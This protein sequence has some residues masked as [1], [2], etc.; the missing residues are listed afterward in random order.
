M[1]SKVKINENSCGNI[2]EIRK[3]LPHGGQQVIAKKLNLSMKTV[4]SILNGRPG[5]VTNNQNVV[6]EAK[7]IITEHEALF[8]K[9]NLENTESNEKN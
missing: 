8:G 2:E 7:I 3:K 4:E 6:R 1:Q 5:L 9:I